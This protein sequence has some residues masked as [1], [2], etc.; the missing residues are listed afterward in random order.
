M[1]TKEQTKQEVKRYLDKASS[2]LFTID[3]K[4]YKV[5]TK[6]D[7]VV[8]IKGGYVWAYNINDAI[9]NYGSNSKNVISN[10]LFLIPR[11]D[12]RLSKHLEIKAIPYYKAAREK[13]KLLEDLIKE[14]MDS[15]EVA[16]SIT[17][18]L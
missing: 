3:G 9:D 13:Y 6:G 15:K 4:E 1:K 2:H 11:F 14:G 18:K 10:Y 7:I 12:Y 8:Y 5:I 17:E 16:K